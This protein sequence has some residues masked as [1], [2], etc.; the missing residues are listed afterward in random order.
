M[1]AVLP[2]LVAPRRT[3]FWVLYFQIGKFLQTTRTF[4]PASL[5]CPFLVCIVILSISRVNQNNGLYLSCFFDLTSIVLTTQRINTKI[6]LGFNDM[7]I[8]VKALIIWMLFLY[9]YYP[10]ITVRIIIVFTA[11]VCLYV[12]SEK[13]YVCFFG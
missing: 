5:Y 7:I 12:Y 3:Y 2:N 13:F 1:D 10:R 9:K 11:E 4:D 8:L 6:C